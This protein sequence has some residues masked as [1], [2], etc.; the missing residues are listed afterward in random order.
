MGDWEP[1]M[2]R[3]SLQ[4]VRLSAALAVLVGGVLGTAG[5]AN[6]APPS[7]DNFASA[8][9]L[10]EP[11]IFNEF[12]FTAGATAQV[13]EPLHA[14]Q[15]PAA[16]IW[17]RWTAPADVVVH[18]S[19]DL[20]MLDSDERPAHALAFYTGSRLT[21]LTPVASAF[22]EQP[23]VT[24]RAKAGTVYNIAINV[25]K[26]DAAQGSTHLFLETQSPN[27][28]LADATKVSGPSGSASGSVGSASLDG[29][30]PRHSLAEGLGGSVWFDWTAPTSGFTRFGVECCASIGTQP[31]MAVYTGSSMS[32]L[33]AVSSSFSCLV[34]AFNTC[35][36][37]HHVKGT[38]YHIAVQGNGST[39]P[40]RWASVGSGCTVPGTA[41]ADTLTGTSGADRICGLGGNDTLRGLGGD[42]LI[43]G[44]PGIDTID[45]SG[46]RVALH[47]DL[48]VA[49]SEGDGSATLQ[50]VENLTGSSL[51][52]IL[53]GNQGANVL[54]GSGGRDH[55]DGGA[56]NDR[57]VGDGGNDV[58]AP[59]A[60]LDA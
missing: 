34:G 13:G 8:T 55:L 32:D 45:Y 26:A 27:D 51:A 6:A 4:P 11:L 5:A 31:V 7:N 33:T 16:S 29:D 38:T 15:A 10:S 54:L 30:E 49:A 18:S 1:Y 60:G 47:A 50:A 44:G 28:D 53:G 14:D 42:D 12:A 36:T 23:T 35:T 25:R 58:L 48:S 39:F 40:L 56:G 2:R 57:L 43:V 52:D 20:T 17:Y 21:S 41:G 9:V 37:F 3:R 19:S 59:G 46:S 22:D 24:F